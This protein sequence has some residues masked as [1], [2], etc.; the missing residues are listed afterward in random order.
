[1]TDFGKGRAYGRQG[2]VANSRRYV[3]KRLISLLVASIF[4]LSLAIPAFAQSGSAKAQKA[5]EKEAKAAARNTKA[6]ERQTKLQERQ[7]KAQA[8]ENA[9]H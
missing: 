5:Q 6:Q 9:R 4:G 8:R 7:A 3:M 1:V 2:V